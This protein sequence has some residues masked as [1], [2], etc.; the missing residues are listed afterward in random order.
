MLITK[1]IEFDAGHRIP[2]HKSKCR[3]FHGHRYKVEVSLEGPIKEATGDSDDGMVLDFSDIKNVL[4]MQV[5]ARFD[6]GFIVWEKDTEGIEALAAL[7]EKHKT[8]IT[9]FVPTAENLA[10]FIF[11]L[12]VGTYHLIYGDRLTLVKVRLFETPTC[13]ADATSFQEL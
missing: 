1:Q 8:I 9:T 13:W 4:M 11:N 3:N 10:Q 7:G 5:D 2:N 6:H 12:L